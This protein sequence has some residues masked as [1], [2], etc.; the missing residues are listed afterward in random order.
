MKESIGIE[1]NDIVSRHVDLSLAEAQTESYPYAIYTN[2]VTPVYTKDG[3]HHYDATVVITIYSADLDEADEIADGIID[4][5]QKY[6]SEGFSARLTSSYPDC[7][8][9]IWSRELTYN[10]KQFN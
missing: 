9:G 8:E 6:L 3:I 5:M 7:V 1:V 2:S 10:I 4:D